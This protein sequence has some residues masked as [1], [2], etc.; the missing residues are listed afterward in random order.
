MPTCFFF[1]FKEILPP[2]TG[3]IRG[4]V[5]SLSENDDMRSTSYDIRPRRRGPFT[6][7]A[8]TNS[9]RRRHG[10]GPGTRRVVSKR[11]GLRQE[12]TLCTGKGTHSRKF[13]E[14]LKNQTLLINALRVFSK[15]MLL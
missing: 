3:Y 8:R 15:I 1:F 12:L 6:S 4:V 9:L 10:S 13:K 11:I 7:T 5:S 14:M 2:V